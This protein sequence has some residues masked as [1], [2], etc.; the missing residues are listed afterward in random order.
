MNHSVSRVDQSLTGPLCQVMTLL[1]EGTWPQ[2]GDEVSGD[3]ETREVIIK[4]WPWPE[5]SKMIHWEVRIRMRIYRGSIPKG[6]L[7]VVTCYVHLKCLSPDPSSPGVN[8]IIG[9]RQCCK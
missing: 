8:D 3:T 9:T 2:A 5:E 7:L 1:Y 6:A 4:S